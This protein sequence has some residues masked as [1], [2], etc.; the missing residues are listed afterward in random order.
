MFKTARYK[1]LFGLIGFIIFSAPQIAWSNEE[2]CE[3]ARQSSQPNYLAKF[4]KL[5]KEKSNLHKIDCDGKNLFY[6]VYGKTRSIDSVTDIRNS[7]YDNLIL[8]LENGYKINHADANKNTPLHLAASK[9]DVNIIYL[10]LEQGAKINAKNKD[11]DT[12]LHLATRY[13]NEE[14]VNLLLH[15]GADR[16]K[17]NKDKKTPLDIAINDA[18]SVEKSRILLQH[19]A[20]PSEK[21]LRYIGN[22]RIADLVE[23]YRELTEKALLRGADEDRLAFTFNPPSP[24]PPQLLPGKQDSPLYTAISKNK[25]DTVRKILSQGID[26]NGLS[27]L[28]NTSL[29]LAIINGYEEIAELLIEAG[30]NVNLENATGN[31][32]LIMAKWNLGII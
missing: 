24:H 17:K 26:V 18:H 22:K 21:T 13:G 5:I 8:L 2:I 31:H 1:C 32:P 25:V 4:E 20:Q 23:K 7:R 27:R 14:A 30:A 15:L 12:P 29:N 19:G 11:K 3:A 10:L 9:G 28:G 16:D 6:V